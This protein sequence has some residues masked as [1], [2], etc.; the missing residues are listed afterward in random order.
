MTQAV[1]PR[2]PAG[3]AR[4]ARKRLAAGWLLTVGL[5]A[6]ACDGSG[7]DGEPA[8][9]TVEATAPASGSELFADPA[10]CRDCH[11]A[12]AAA[13]SGSHHDLAMQVATPETVLGD[14]GAAA[15]DERGTM[16]RFGRAGDRF[17]VETEGPDGKVGR[18]EIAYTF[19]V[20][21]LQQ[22]LVSFPGGRLQA[23]TVAWDVAGGRW[24]SLY[25]DEDVAPDDPLHWTGPAMRWNR[26]CAECHS[27]ALERGY[28]P[29]EDRYDTRWVALDVSCQAC[30]GPGAA[31]VRWARALAPGAPVPESADRELVGGLVRGD[32]PGEIETCAPCHARR[33][34]VSARSVPGEPLLDHHAPEW[35]WPDL[36]FAD[37]Q[38]DGEVYVYG[39]FVQSRMH[40]RGVRCSDCHE[41]HA[42]GLR[43]EGNALCTRCHSPEPDVRFPSL[44]ARLYDDPAHHFHPEGEPAAA[45]VACH[46]PARTYMRVDPRRDHSLRV[47]RPDL[48]VS[49]GTPNACN[50]CHTD[51]DARW[52]AGVLDARRPDGVVLPDHFGEAL[53][54]ARAGAPDAASRLRVLVADP[55]APGIARATAVAMLSQPLSADDAASV[56]RSARDGD[57]LVRLAAARALE[58]ADP[59]LAVP[60]LADLVS[61]ARRAVRGEAARSLAGLPR[62]D[63]S[64]AQQAAFARALDAYRAGLQAQADTSEAQL[65][66]GVLAARRG[67]PGAAESAYRRA[68]DLQRDFVPA[69]VNLANLL[70]AQ[71]RDEQALAQ[72]RQGLAAATRLLATDGTAAARATTGEIHY[73]MGLLLAEMGR[74]EEAA[75]ELDRAAAL[76]HSRARVHYNHGLALHQLGRAGE[77]EAA[78]GRAAVLDPDDAGI[79]QALAVLYAQAGERDAALRHARRSLELSGGAPAARELLRRIETLP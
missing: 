25:P 17:W 64:S 29:A 56:A 28:Q 4:R 58:G 16:T 52:A 69:H 24:L 46:M 78:L 77:A 35:L 39:S 36:Y 76:L 70:A 47:P 37:G 68:L 32:A 63:L 19:G 31:H 53:A 13:W 6:S 11:P 66:L 49:I 61:D 40:R 65:A 43:A 72:L 48:T 38:I 12:A 34:A 51:R 59:A 50:G 1:V 2:W 20:D 60:L 33:Y 26:T 44:A 7:V 73:S 79:Q 62:G 30:H 14:F 57:P 10:S 18:Y 27:T 23:L 67:R 9:P 15:F 8:A 22:Y 41:P 5:L 42:L 3:V 45:C 75:T 21:P 74:L 55:E 71:G 54:A